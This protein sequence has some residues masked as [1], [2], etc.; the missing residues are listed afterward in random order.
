M[1]Y[2]H[3]FCAIV[4]AQLRSSIRAIVQQEDSI[5]AVRQ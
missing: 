3:L 2:P 1:T 5:N 4:A